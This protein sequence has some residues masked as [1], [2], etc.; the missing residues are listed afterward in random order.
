MTGQ[1]EA[2]SALTDFLNQIGGEE[3][4]ICID[5]QPRTVSR[6]EALARKMYLLAL[7]GIEEVQDVDGQVVKVFHK[8][9]YRVSKMIREF[10]EGKAPMEVVETGTKGRKPGSFNSAV[11]NRLSNRLGP[12]RPVMSKSKGT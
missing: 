11:A 6:A 4:T 9:D 7:G 3:V 1:T 10:T 2:K 8:P 5:G 12:R